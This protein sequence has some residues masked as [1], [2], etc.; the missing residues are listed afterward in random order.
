MLGWRWWKLASPFSVR[1]FFCC[2]SILA[3]G[4]AEGGRW[5]KW[6]WGMCFSF[7]PLYMHHRI[8]WVTIASRGYSYYQK[9]LGPVVGLEK[10]RWAK[11]NNFSFH[12]RTSFNNVHFF[13]YWPFVGAHLFPAICEGSIDRKLIP[14]IWWMGWCTLPIGWE[15]KFLWC[16]CMEN[17]EE[18]CKRAVF[19]GDWVGYVPDASLRK[20]AVGYG[21][22]WRHVQSTL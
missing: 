3:I 9:S 8:F 18:G 11:S 4:I 13:S 5:S 1:T 14:P 19:D 22:F 10:R 17:M 21:C 16:T 2:L 12:L 6:L 15:R 7:F 20:P